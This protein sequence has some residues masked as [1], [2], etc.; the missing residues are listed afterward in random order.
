MKGHKALWLVAAALALLPARTAHAGFQYQSTIV[1]ENAASNTTDF[2]LTKPGTGKV[3]I[4][5]STKAG[6]GGSTIQL[7]LKGVDCVN[8][9]NDASKTGKCGNSGSGG[10]TDHVMELGVR[11]LGTE[12]PGSIEALPDS[13]SVAGIKFKYVK[14]TALFQATGKNVISGAVFGAGT[15]VI[16]N[17][18][19]GIGLIRLR[20]P[21]SVP[22][23]C[24]SA[25]SGPGCSDGIVYAFTGIQMGSDS[26][27]HCSGDTSCSITQ[28]CQSGSCATQTCSS[29]GDCRSGHCGTGSNAGNCCDPALTPAT[30]P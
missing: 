18:P 28:T 4:K 10:V 29:G 23:D 24:D 21:G 27:L 16:F 14:G 1:A 13:A 9:G 22:T 12:F 25:P 2:K 3:V 15:T 20:T 8:E 19:L 30:C 7:V 26:S 5:P 17:Q 11:A 6:G